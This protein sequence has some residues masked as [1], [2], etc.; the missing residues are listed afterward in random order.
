M[1][2][3]VKHGKDKIEVEVA[4]TMSIGEFKKAVEEKTSIPVSNQKLLYMGKQLSNNESSLT[5]VGV[6]DKGVLM[7]TGCTSEEAKAA[8]VKPT[9]TSTTNILTGEVTPVKPLCEETQHAKVIEAGPPETETPGDLSLGN[10][11]LPIEAD[12]RVPYVRDVLNG[13][14]QKMRIRILSKENKMV[15]ASESDMQNL[16]FH[17]ISKITSEPIKSHPQYHIVVLHLRDSH[18]SKLFLYWFPCQYVQNLKNII[19]GF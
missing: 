12:T 13:A 3:K 1:K 5:D 16:P 11:P 2:L 6:K 14:K 7:V 8:A 19:F 17:S 9:V 4:D 18:N 15:M 10:R